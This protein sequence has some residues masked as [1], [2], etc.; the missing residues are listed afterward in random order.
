[1]VRTRRIAAARRWVAVGI[2]N[3]IVVGNVGDVDGLDRLSRETASLDASRP[4]AIVCASGSRSNVACSLLRQQGF[5]GELYN[6][7]GGTTAWVAAGFET[8]RP[9]L[10]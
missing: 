9:E 4:L 3:V 7:A 8:D 10:S 2:E 1:M 5:T 6:V